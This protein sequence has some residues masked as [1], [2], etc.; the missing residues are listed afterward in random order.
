VAATGQG[1]EV[2]A[3]A[4]DPVEFTF[5]HYAGGNQDTV[6][7]DVVNQ[8]MQDNP[9]VK[10]NL[11]AGSNLATMPGIVAS[12]K[13]TGA[14]SVNAG[15]FNSAAVATGDVNDLWASLD[16]QSMPNLKGIPDAY[17]RPGGKG[18][19]WGVSAVGI[20]YR[21]DKV[22]PPPS[23]WMDLLDPR[24]KGRVGLTDLSFPIS[25]LYAVNRI[26]GG[27]ERNI[28][29]GIAA[30]SEA[31]KNGQFAAIAENTGTVMKDMALAGTFDIWGETRS[32]L[33]AFE[34][35]GAPLAFA[36]PKEGIVAFPLS[37]E[38]LVGNTPA[39]AYHAARILNLLLSVDNLSRYSD[40]TL[41][42]VTNPNVT[43]SD[44]LKNDP[45]FAPDVVKNAIQIDWVASAENATS[46]LDKWNQQVKANLS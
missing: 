12:V 13:T 42:A 38:I 6:P 41:T 2:P 5:F 28:D 11:Q 4:K 10:V 18:V 44:K 17:Q 15:Y 29:P 26:L 46:D 30:F 27:D 7:T 21:K 40:L 8:Y 3:F 35:K 1:A 22:D 31:A 33:F 39:Q 14:P 16:P 20:A 43:L 25:G 32:S 36:V 23:S 37:F 24:F 34:D 19:S 45:S 9:N